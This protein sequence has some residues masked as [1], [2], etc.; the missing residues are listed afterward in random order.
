MLCEKQTGA[1]TK[2][3]DKWIQLVQP[4]TVLVRLRVN[5]VQ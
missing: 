1:S 4:P 5:A 2:L 3:W